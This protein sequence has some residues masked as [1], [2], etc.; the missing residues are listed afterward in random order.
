MRN[1]KLYSI[2]ILAIT[3][4]F[5][6]NVSSCSPGTTPEENNP[7]PNI[8]I[9]FTEPFSDPGVDD[10]LAALINKHPATEYLDLCF[11]GLDRE[12]IL[13][14]IEQ[15]I[16]RGVHVRFVGNKDGSGTVES[17][18]G[19]YYEGYHRIA[20]ALDAEF[21]ITGKK[22]INFPTD[23]GFDDFILTNSSIMHNKFLLS[24]DP[25]GN[26]H[27]YMGT[28]NCT[29]TGFERNNNGS[30]VF[31]HAGI[32]D[33]YRAQF[34]Y[35][36]G[37]SGSSPVSSVATH[38]IDGI[39]VDVLFAPQKL[40]GKTV[41]DH[42]MERVAAADSS[43]HFMIFSFPHRDLND[44]I[45]QKHQSSI[46]VKGVFDQ[47]QLSNSSEE[48]LAQRG[49]PCKIDGNYHN[50]GSHGGKL[51]HKT[52]ILDYSQDDAVVA[53]GSFNWSDN[54]NENNDENLIFIHSKKIAGIYMEE[55]TKRWDEGTEVATVSEG[56][57]AQYQDV[58][59]NEVMW[60]GNRNN[61]ETA[62]WQDEF[63][64]LKNRTA[65]TIDLS[66]WAIKG[67]SMSGKALLLSDCY[68]LP[69]EMLVI[70]TLSFSESAYS[71]ARH[72]MIDDLCISNGRIELVL[73][74]PDCTAI[75]YAGDGSEGDDFA[76]VNGS[77]STGPKKSMARNDSYS[78]GTLSANWFTS[79]TQENINTDYLT[80]TFGTP[81][82]ENNSGA[83]SYNELDIVFSE[84]AWAGTDTSTYDEWVELYNNT[85]SDIDLG[86]WSI[87]GA[88]TLE[89]T[90]TIPA[91]SHFLLE[92][93]NDDS[94]PGKTADQLYTGGLSNSGA[95]ISLIYNS[96]TID[97]ISMSSGWA[98]GSSSPKLSMERS[99]LTIPGGNSNWQ[100]GA[101]DVEGAQN[102]SD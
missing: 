32:Y 27:L 42:L 14:A 76:G 10:A 72:K 70:H 6:F 93:T 65:Q 37:L 38:T 88:L 84:V 97:S 71:P 15:A 66:G 55:W 30:I 7:T 79:N 67:G 60:M 99:N 12:N 63:I 59:I 92:R 49:V 80:Y 39:R 64:E 83:V 50:E 36:L 1:K 35:L 69:N 62:T 5:I 13:T 73:E 91:Y 53:T 68:I 4:L 31:K 28:T 95:D 20:R 101:G 19:D 21:P 102:S 24:L 2:L 23:T 82:E 46:E 85:A 43:I 58:L 9:Y 26:K 86:A 51:H 81:G 45:L 94:V 74:D 18:T 90:G 33:T 3:V 89:L 22:R 56:D 17:E 78:D 98:A 61:S 16:N 75:D 25:E 54:A 40:D 48:Y 41:M 87:S 96:T 77:G 47:S 44:L 57:H 11:Y 100:N 52:M 34:E 8:R 29:D